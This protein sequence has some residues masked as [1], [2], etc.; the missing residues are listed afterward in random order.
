MKVKQ[1]INTTI[2][3][4][5]TEINTFASVVRKINK[6]YRQTGLK[7]DLPVLNDE[8]KILLERLEDLTETES[9]NG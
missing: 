9:E 2:V 8:E 6:A 7:K 3:F 5:H 4:V 1:K